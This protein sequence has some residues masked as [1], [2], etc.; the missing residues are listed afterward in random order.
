VLARLAERFGVE[1]SPYP[2]QV[3][4]E[5]SAI[6]F[7]GRPYGEVGEE[8]PLPEPVP[9]SRVQGPGPRT[10][11]EE[12]GRNGGLRLVTY[13]PLLSGPAVERVPELRFQEPDPEV[14]LAPPDAARLGISKGDE[15]TVRSNGTSVTLRA[16]ADDDLST[17]A[18]R[19]AAPHAGGLEGTVEVLT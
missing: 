7:G 6:V 18:V 12:T 1:L 15:V 5:V 10:G 11:P 8:A 3:F 4:D 17:G 9:G 13:R 14:E 2:S 16:L 19:I